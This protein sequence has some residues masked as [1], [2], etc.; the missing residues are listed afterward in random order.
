LVTPR[1]AV[2]IHWGTLAARRP[3]RRHP[4]PGRPPQE[5]AAL[6]AQRAPGVEVRVLAPGERTV[7][8]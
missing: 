6:V 5:F 3:M 2:P 7:V 4:D 1:V 8:E